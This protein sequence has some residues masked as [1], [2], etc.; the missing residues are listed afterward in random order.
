M[1]TDL[2]DQVN[3]ILIDDRWSADVQIPALILDWIEYG[4][5][6]RRR[7]DRFVQIPLSDLRKLVRWA[8]ARTRNEA[9]RIALADASA[10]LEKE[11]GN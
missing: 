5:R 1:S 11:I 8:L 10:S 2:G 9:M 6:T 7:G 4:K 3:M